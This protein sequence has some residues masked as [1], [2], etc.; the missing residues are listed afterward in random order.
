MPLPTTGPLSLNDLHVEAG[1]TTG[2]TC[3]LNDEDIRDLIGKGNNASNGI[4]EYRGASRDVSF[5]YELIG[6]GGAG[7][8]GRSDGSGSGTAPSGGN[9]EISGSGFTTVSS[10]GGAGGRNSVISPSTMTG[11]SGEASFYGSGGSGGANAAP[12]GDA[13][14]SSYGAGGG[15]A[16][17]DPSGFLD[18][19]GYAGEGGFAATRVTGS[20]SLQYGTVLTITIGTKGLGPTGFQG[21]HGGDGADGYVKITIGN[22]VHEFTSSGTLTL[23]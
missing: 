20:A 3:S 7:G 16:G 12:G 13:P 2:T 9:T 14:A 23:Q 18:A 6:G 15:G 11:R 1:G 21:R 10:A 17:G 8:Y 19:A 22:T 5:T 4:V